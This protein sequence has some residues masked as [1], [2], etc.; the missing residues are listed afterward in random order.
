MVLAPN[1]AML[2]YVI[3]DKLLMAVVADKGDIVDGNVG[4]INASV[5]EAVAKVK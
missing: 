2:A 3:G 5:S 1:A 4:G